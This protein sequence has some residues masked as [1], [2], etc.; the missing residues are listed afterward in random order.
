[1]SSG[2]IQTFIDF[3]FLLNLEVDRYVWLRKLSRLS[4]MT[5]LNQLN[6]CFCLLSNQTKLCTESYRLYVQYCLFAFSLL[7]PLLK[8]YCQLWWFS[9]N[10]TW[11]YDHS[12]I[13]NC[14]TRIVFPLFFQPSLRIRVCSLATRAAI[15]CC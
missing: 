5:R 13:G 3:P 15:K 10:C 9:F 8:E 1:M 11:N 14:L 2:I 7:L 4:S 12:L 6:N